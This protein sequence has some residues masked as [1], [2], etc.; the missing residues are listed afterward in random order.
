MPLPPRIPRS[1]ADAIRGAAGFLSGLAEKLEPGPNSPQERANLYADR[2]LRELLD[3][4]LLQQASRPASTKLEFLT[5]LRLL[6]E[7]SEETATLLEECAKNLSPTIPYAETDLGRRAQEI[8]RLLIN[9]EAAQERLQASAA[10]PGAYWGLQAPGDHLATM[11]KLP[12]L[13][14]ERFEQFLFTAGSSDVAWDEYRKT[15]DFLDLGD[16]TP[17]SL[18]ESFLVFHDRHRGRF[19]KFV[20]VRDS[21][22]EPGLQFLLDKRLPPQGPLSNP[23]H[24]SDPS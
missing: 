1:L 21:H 10:T 18:S 15:H 3:A 5:M 2:M 11:P 17:E 8:R 12:D 14:F 22:A 13:S 19:L 24:P 20:L 6:F 23:N 4:E 9:L 16:R 7:H